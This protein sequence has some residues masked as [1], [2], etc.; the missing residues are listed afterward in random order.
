MIRS[1]SQRR[2][3]FSLVEMMAALIIFSIGVLAVL[4]VIATS[5]R[6]TT[7]TLGYTQAVFL[8]QQQL[9]EALLDAPLSAGSE[10]G[11][12]GSAFPN[13]SWKKEIEE[14]EAQK[15]YSVRV[16]VTWRERGRDRRYSL[17]TLAAGRQ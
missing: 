15:L 12:F 16:D 8:A 14:V 10:S 13:H 11:E 7:A 6:S 4:E 17:T 9:E 3:A 5:L 2:R 1:I